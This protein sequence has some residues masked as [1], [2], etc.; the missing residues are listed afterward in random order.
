MTEPS[1]WTIVLAEAARKQDEYAA[2]RRQHTDTYLQTH[3]NCVTDGYSDDAR[4]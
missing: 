4:K 1:S 3:G 2:K